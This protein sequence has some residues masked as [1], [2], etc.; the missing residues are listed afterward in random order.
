MRL[1]AAT[2]TGPAVPGSQLSSSR[3]PADRRPAHPHLATLRRA[4]PPGH[5]ALPL[6]P[7]HLRAP[8]P[9]PPP[10]AR[11]W[12]CRHGTPPRAERHPR[13]GR[14]PGPTLSRAHRRAAVFTKP[15]RRTPPVRFAPGPA[16]A[17]AGPARELALKG[18]RVASQR[19]KLAGATPAGRP[20]QPRRWAGRGR[21]AAS[22]APGRPKGDV[23]RTLAEGR[24][25][26]SPTGLLSAPASPRTREV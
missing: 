20:G 6:G 9:V 16:P 24:P 22:A 25:I 5:A 7:G 15:E 2:R 1:S 4:D 17:A 11:G 21:Q 18:A 10:A 3:S 19:G 12:G 23:R 13:S 26:N 8:Q 14:T